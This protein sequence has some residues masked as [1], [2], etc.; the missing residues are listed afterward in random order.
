MNP[1]TGEY[2]LLDAKTFTFSNSAGL[3]LVVENIFFPL[4]KTE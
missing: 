4:M 2:H 3:E 1:L